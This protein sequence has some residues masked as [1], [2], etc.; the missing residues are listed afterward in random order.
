MEKFYAPSQHLIRYYT[1]LSKYFIC[2]NSISFKIV[3][4]FLD[5]FLEKLWHFIL[6][7]PEPYKVLTP[8]LIY[9]IKVI[10]RDRPFI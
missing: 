2:R 7:E 3:I 9:F 1:V 6:E 8:V 10:P 5:K 4:K